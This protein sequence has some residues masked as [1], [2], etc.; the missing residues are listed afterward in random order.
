MDVPSGLEAQLGPLDASLR[1]FA[2][3]RG[4]DRL[5]EARSRAASTLQEGEDRAREVLAKARAE[6]ERAAEREASRRLVHAR[7]EAR[8]QIL[9]AQREA[10]ERLTTAAISAARE[11]RHRPEYPELEKRLS[12]AA[13]DLL[14]ADAEIIRDPEGGGGVKARKG[15]RSVDLS[16]A[17]LALRCVEESSETISRLWR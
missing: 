6:G 5:R 12:D 9:R 15:S 16:L 1:S 13:L 8:R 11:L 2:R 17:A 4:E 10:Y 14:G 7:R 3:E